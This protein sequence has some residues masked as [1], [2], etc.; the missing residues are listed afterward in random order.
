MK[1]QTVGVIGAGIMG[2]G[3]SQNL[4][5]T[6]HQVILL[7]I[8]EDILKRAKQELSN[9]VRIQRLLNKDKG[10]E[11]TKNLLAQ[12]IFS[13]DHRL[14][15]SADF[16]I[17]CVTEK[18]DIKRDVYMAIDQVCVDSCVFASNTSAI[19]ITRIA[20]ATRRT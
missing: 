10:I 15:V 13:T 17:E 1:I 9:N 7:D 14:L 3:L 18:W 2:V 12:I 8:S 11:K 6:G 4:G 16:V 20:S 19:P 5:Q